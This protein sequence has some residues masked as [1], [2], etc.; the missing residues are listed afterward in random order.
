MHV[1]GADPFLVEQSLGGGEALLPGETDLQRR[2]LLRAQTDDR[3]FLVDDLPPV[4]EDEAEAHLGVVEGAVPAVALPRIGAVDHAGQALE[5]AVPIHRLVAVLARP[6]ALDLCGQ[7]VLTV[8][9]R[10]DS[11]N[12][13]D[14]TPYQTDWLKLVA[15]APFF[16]DP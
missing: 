3:R 4:G 9:R 2:V 8:G 5:V 7:L 13:R 14:D 12:Q 15:F 10:E 11:E 16:L 1:G 6:Q